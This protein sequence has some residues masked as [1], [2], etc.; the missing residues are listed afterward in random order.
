VLDVVELENIVVVDEEVTVSEILTTERKFDA[1]SP[2]FP[3]TVMR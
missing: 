1:K 2:L 3:V